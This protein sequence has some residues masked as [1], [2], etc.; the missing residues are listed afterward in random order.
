MKTEHILLSVSLYKP[1]QKGTS[2]NEINTERNLTHVG[3]IEESS[4][5]AIVH[6]RMQHR[7]IRTAVDHRHIPTSKW[8]HLRVQLKVQRVKRSALE[9]LSYVRDNMDERC[10]VSKKR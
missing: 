10:Y 3:H 7:A 5:S 1:S 4:S 6:M 8:N 2:K 9:R